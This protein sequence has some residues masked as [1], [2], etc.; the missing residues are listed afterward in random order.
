[1]KEDEL[2]SDFFP[3]NSLIVI[4]QMEQTLLTP[5]FRGVILH[6][7]TDSRSSGGKNNVFPK[8]RLQTT[9]LF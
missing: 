6:L 3:E 2:V 4:D 7:A 8:L 1:M 5:E 9:C